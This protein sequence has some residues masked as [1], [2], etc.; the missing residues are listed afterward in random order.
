ME[1][2]GHMLPTANLSTARYREDTYASLGDEWGY[3][4]PLGERRELWTMWDSDCEQC[5]SWNGFKR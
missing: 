4:P 2:L 3:P 1:G 5:A